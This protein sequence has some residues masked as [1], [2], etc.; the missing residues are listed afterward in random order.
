MPPIPQEVWNRIEVI[1]AEALSHLGARVQELCP[2]AQS[3]PWSR[4]TNAAPL[5]VYRTFRYILEEPIVVGVTF[6]QGG[7]V[8]VPLEGNGERTRQLYP[9]KISARANIF[10]ERTGQIYLGKEDLTIP[11]R[12]EDLL[13]IIN[14]M[15]VP[16]IEA[17]AAPLSSILMLL[18]DSPPKEII[19]TWL[20]AAEINEKK[21]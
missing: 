21:N 5:L 20:R 17:W 1:L 12:T 7:V 4:R 19:T 6:I 14:L 11:P 13:A 18:A 10:S 16:T 3:H 8:E 15:L 2:Q 9:D